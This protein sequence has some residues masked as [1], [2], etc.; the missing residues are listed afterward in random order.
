M[1]MIQNRVV[2]VWLP[3]EQESYETCLLFLVTETVESEQ[4][5]HVHKGF[6]LD[7]VVVN[8]E[9]TETFYVGAPAEIVDANI[10]PRAR[11]TDLKYS[12]TMVLV[13][14]VHKGDGRQHLLWRCAEYKEMHK[15][16]GEKYEKTGI[17]FAKRIAAG[18]GIQS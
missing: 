15:C 10:V 13:D 14:A 3:S 5:G 11:S 17:N 8:H 2:A 4:D 16:A 9:G 7:E 1:A 18:M 12:L 6:W